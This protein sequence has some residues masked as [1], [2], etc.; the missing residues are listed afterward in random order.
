MVRD[1]RFDLGMLTDSVK[2]AAALMV[3]A[4]C[5]AASA[6]DEA[7]ELPEW[8]NSKI[9]LE[10]IV[11]PG[12]GPVRTS[13][14]EVDLWGRRYVWDESFL[15]AEI[16]SQNEAL[17]GPLLLVATVENDRRVLRPEKVEIT[18]SAPDHAVVVARGEA[19]PGLRVTCTTRIE[20]DGVA[21]VELLIVPEGSVTID[22]LYN[23]ASIVRSKSARPVIF[24]ASANPNSSNNIRYMRKEVLF[25]ADYHGSF[26]NVLG[27]PDG[28]RSFWWFADNAK[29]WIWNGPNVTELSIR[30]DRFLLRQH[31]IGGSWS[32]DKPMSFHFNFLATPVR[33][34]GSA[35]RG[36]RVVHYMPVTKENR[37]K[38]NL[39]WPDAFAH[40]ALPYSQLPPDIRKEFPNEDWDK[41]P[42]RERTKQLMREYA[43]K[44]FHRLPYMSAH[45]LSIFDPFGRKYRT[46]WE[47]DP[48]WVHH[49]DEAVTPCFSHRAA[50][51]SNYLLSRFSNEID[52]LGMTGVYLDQGAPVDSR[53]MAH[54]GWIDSNGK[55]Q[56]SLDIL[57]YREFLKRLRTLFFLK[58]K[59]GYVVAHDSNTELIPA[60]TFAAMTLDGEQFVITLKDDDYI[61]SVSLD[62]VRSLYRGTQFGIVSTWL[63]E[64]LPRHR[65]EPGW[66]KSGAQYR[67]YRN[68]MTLALL[69]DI[70]ILPVGVSR[71]DYQSLTQDLDDFGVAHS[72]F[73][74]YW[75][76]DAGAQSTTTD[77]PISFYRFHNGTKALLVVAN[78]SS[79]QKAI[80][81][82]VDP[83]A[84]GL[85]GDAFSYRPIPLKTKLLPQ[86]G[87]VQVNVSGRD[88]RLVE[89]TASH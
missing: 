2:F 86:D 60:L 4:T 20:Y 31:L 33:D 10:P 76:E 70:P 25:D 73:V 79:M 8:W 38:F 3:L 52:E 72:D 77:A 5:V 27:F 65:H 83:I 39:W 34:I 61:G 32:I 85:H 53:N 48:P 21:M 14:T 28:D 29:G 36:E 68:L 62:K 16:D 57:A 58:G 19:L 15:P 78:L 23:E 41:F 30:G 26:R 82:V 66:N 35:W 54:G 12:F 13:G 49:F 24:E 50:G 46:Q 56:A 18:E 80:D 37:G 87:R 71:S 67:A 89:I 51:Y 44:D 45:C 55:K 7:E 63:P 17:T 42:G 22:G 74:G 47:T 88:F 43:A 84:L 11:L 81:L 40:Y 64:L 75:R 6:G 69:H 1:K 59:P 9:G